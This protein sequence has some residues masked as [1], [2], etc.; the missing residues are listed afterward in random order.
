VEDAGV[1]PVRVREEDFP[2]AELPDNATPFERLI[3]YTI[4]GYWIRPG[5][6]RVPGLLERTARAEKLAFT[7]III[8]SIPALHSLGVP[9]DVIGN[10]ITT[11]ITEAF[12]IG[13]AP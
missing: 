10:W 9:T 8:L 3:Y 2:A 11:H 5:G 4:F 6:K 1:I 13:T 12:R 7:L